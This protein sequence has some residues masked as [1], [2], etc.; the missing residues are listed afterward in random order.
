MGAEADEHTYELLN[1]PEETGELYRAEDPRPA[2]D[3]VMASLPLVASADALLEQADD[4]ALQFGLLEQDTG[5][6][7][8]YEGW[9]WKQDGELETYVQPFQTMDRATYR[10]RAPDTIDTLPWCQ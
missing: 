10:D 1:G 4:Y 3:A 6:V 8:V 7:H 2:A 9:A 5:R